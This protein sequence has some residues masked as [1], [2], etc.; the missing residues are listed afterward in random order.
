MN[1][2]KEW[3]FN[4]WIS[5]IIRRIIW[6]DLPLTCSFIWSLCA[7]LDQKCRASFGGVGNIKM[8]HITAVNTQFDAF[9]FVGGVLRPCYH[10]K[11]A[12]FSLE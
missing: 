3:N 11:V 2:A 9:P 7:A 5:L 6:A 1:I 10:Q 8:N 4:F 12:S